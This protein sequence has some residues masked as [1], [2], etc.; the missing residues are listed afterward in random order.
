MQLNEAHEDFERIRILQEKLRQAL[1]RW[2]EIDEETKDF[3]HLAVVADELE[4]A[5]REL[6]RRRAKASAT[7]LCRL[8]GWA[9]LVA[10]LVFLAL[11]VFG[12]WNAALLVMTVVAV[13]S[14][15]VLLAVGGRR[16]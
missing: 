5:L 4:D 6:Q 12:G 13:T 8:G 10:G 2:D 15:A 11:A 9:G 1:G 3:G 16:V 7:R 14:G